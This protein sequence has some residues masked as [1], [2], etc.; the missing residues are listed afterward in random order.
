M[1]EVLVN[2]LGGLSLPRKS[3][4]RLTDRP[5][6]TLDVYRGRKT[7]IQ[8][9]QHS[10]KTFSSSSIQR[11]QWKQKRIL[12]TTRFHFN[13]AVPALNSPPSPMLSRFIFHDNMVRPENPSLSVY[14]YEVCFHQSLFSP[15]SD[16]NQLISLNKTIILFIHN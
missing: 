16:F 4:V 10:M 12:I 8:Q 7:T 3:V 15:M 2:R 14:L 13:K 11:T 5:D 1:H 6:M 9:Q